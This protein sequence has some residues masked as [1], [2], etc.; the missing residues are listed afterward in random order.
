MK[1]IVCT[2]YG[3]PDVLELREVPMPEPRANEIRIRVHASTVATSGGFMRRGEPRFTRLFT[4]LT[5][6]R[7]SIPGTD[8]AGIVDAVGAEVTQFQPGDRLIAATDTG[9]GAHAEFVCVS[10]DAAIVPMPAN[11]SFEEAA[12]L[13]EGGLTAIAFLRDHARLRPGQSILIIGASGAIGTAAVQLA[14]SFDAR[15]TGV[16]STANRELVQSLGP[17]CVIDYSKEPYTTGATAYDIVFD[18]VGKSSF[19]ECRGILLDGGLYMTPVL[20]AAIL[21]HM[22]WTSKFGR[23]KALFAATGLCP[24]AKKM[25]DLHVLKGLAEAGKLKSVIDR[26]CPLEEAADAARYVDGGHKRGNVVL[27]MNSAD[28]V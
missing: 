8:L 1:A 22:A 24:A 23:K 19:R 18:T 16:C 4:G 15:V 6:P 20:S 14:K 27:R 25:E 10:E 7:F 9:F 21:I 12:C 26:V 17:D 3:P 28:D 11:M 2:R 13:C 5:K